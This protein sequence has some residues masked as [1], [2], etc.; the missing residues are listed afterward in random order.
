MGRYEPAAAIA[1][2]SINPLTPAAFPETDPAIVPLRKVLGDPV[3][4]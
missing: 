2:F 3:Y 1:G 4:E